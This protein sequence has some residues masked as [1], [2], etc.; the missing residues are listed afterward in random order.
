MRFQKKKN[1]SKKASLNRTQ[2]RQNLEDGEKFM[3]LESKFR[4]I[5]L[6]QSA[7]LTAFA[8]FKK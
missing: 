2:H 8:I 7:N 1:H 5:K 3:Q 4:A 6:Q